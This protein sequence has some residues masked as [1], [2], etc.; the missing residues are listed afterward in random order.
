MIASVA[1]GVTIWALAFLG[2]ALIA[3]PVGILVAVAFFVT[4]MVLGVL[5]QRD[6]EDK[7]IVIPK[8]RDEP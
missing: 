4:S 1:L 6:L 5:S 2:A 7:Y 3:G 8:D